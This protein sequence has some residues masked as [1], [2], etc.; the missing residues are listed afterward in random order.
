MPNPPRTTCN[1][2]RYPDAE[3]AARGMILTQE[4]NHSRGRPKWNR[5]LHVYL[6]PECGRWHVGHGRGVVKAGW[7]QDGQEKTQ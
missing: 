4:L 3:S 2:R 1:K 5:G 7:T 6:C